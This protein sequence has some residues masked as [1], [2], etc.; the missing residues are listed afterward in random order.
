MDTEVIKHH[1]QTCVF[2]CITPYSVNVKNIL[3]L[4]APFMNM[5]KRLIGG[6]SDAGC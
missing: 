3:M 6:L 5:H 4:L 1:T 2:S